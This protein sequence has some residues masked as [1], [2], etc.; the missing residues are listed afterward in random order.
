GPMTSGG[1]GRFRGGATMRERSRRLERGEG[2]FGLLIALVL[3][4]VVVTAGVKIIP[5]HIHGAE[6]FDA[7]NEAA[8]F[9]GLKPVEKLQDELYTKAQE[10][11]VPVKP[12]N[13][14]V[15]RNGGYVVV[16]V[17]YQETVDVFTYKYV[18]NFDKKV[19]KLVF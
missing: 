2:M 4:F 5:L 11:R 15:V 7:M 8:N 17:R 16:Q 14:T 9:G 3:L 6:M 18:Y 19:E 10:I 1:A 12:Q 13:V